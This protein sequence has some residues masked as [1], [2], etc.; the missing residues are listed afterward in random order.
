MDIARAKYHL[1]IDLSKVY[2]QVQIELEDIW[3][4][5]F[6]TIYGTFISQVMQQGDCNAPVMFNDSDL[7]LE[8]TLDMVYMSAS[9]I[10]SFTATHWRIMKD[11]SQLYSTSLKKLIST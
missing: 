11:T 2:K 4:M 8:I 3:K 7:K 1:K 9:I 6:T 5:A 10:Y